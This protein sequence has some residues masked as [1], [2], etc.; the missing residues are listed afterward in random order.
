FHR[1]VIEN[2]I[3]NLDLY[4]K[5]RDEIE[6]ALTQEVSGLDMKN[7]NPD[8]LKGI[9]KKAFE[10]EERLILDFIDQNRNKPVRIKGNPYF[11]H[12]WKRQNKR[13]RAQMPMT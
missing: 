7:P 13:L 1:M 6:Q 2:R 5:R 11:R 9:M 3:Q 10:E 12:Y 8:I 4:I